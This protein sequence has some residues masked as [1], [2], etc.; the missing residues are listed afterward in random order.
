MWHS[1]KVPTLSPPQ[2][3]EKPFHLLPRYFSFHPTFPLSQKEVT[4]SIGYD[5][6]ADYLFGAKKK[7]HKFCKTCGSSILIDFKRMEYGETDPEKDKLAVNVGSAIFIY[8]TPLSAYVRCLRPLLPS[9]TS[10]SH[11]PMELLNPPKDKSPF[12]SLSRLL[13]T[14]K[15]NQFLY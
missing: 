15:R 14:S 11:T 3:I 9:Q 5:N 13:Y 12:H 10:S 6:L 2:L 7:P 8:S 4:R 1:A